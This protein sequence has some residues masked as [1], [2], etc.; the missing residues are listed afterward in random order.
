MVGIGKGVAVPVGAGGASGVYVAE[1]VLVCLMETGRGKLLQ[2]VKTKANR[3]PKRTRRW[4]IGVLILVK[5]RGVNGQGVVKNGSD[6]NVVNGV[7]SRETLDSTPNNSLVPPKDE[8][9][10]PVTYFRYNEIRVVLVEEIMQRPNNH[11]QVLDTRS[12]NEMC[13]L[14][15]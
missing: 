1:G 4:F 6:S 13:S 5:W 2:A 7:Q 15:T 11:S 9:F 14:W 12:F 10:A 8:K 3:S